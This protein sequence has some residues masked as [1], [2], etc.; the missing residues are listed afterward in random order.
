MGE[1]GT[2]NYRLPVEILPH[3]FR[4]YQSE[5]ASDFVLEHYSIRLLM[6]EKDHNHNTS[7]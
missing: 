1:P 4:H 3:M 6:T 7:G 2:A 5:D